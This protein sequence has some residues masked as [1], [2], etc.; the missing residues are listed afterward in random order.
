MLEHLPKVFGRA[1]RNARPGLERLTINRPE[2]KVAQSIGVT[3]SAFENDMPIPRRYTADGD[4]I[5]PPLEW[6]GVPNGTAC[7]GLIIE[8]ADSP[9]PRPLVHAIAPSLPVRGNL[10]EGGLSSQEQ[11]IQQGRNSY[12]THRY[13]PPDPPP[14]HGPHRYAFQ[15]FALSESS[16]EATGMGRGAFI[17][18]V[19]RCAIAKG[20]LIGRYE[21]R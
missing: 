21:R 14:G 1:L 9:T 17:K 19:K 7:I 5:S 16:R 20:C 6:H 2:I 11:R 8:D 15:I 10:S 13:L 4:G 18:W 12:F 3:S